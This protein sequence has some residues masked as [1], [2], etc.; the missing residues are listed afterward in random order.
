MGLPT[1]AAL[2]WS[3]RG[4]AVNGPDVE[5]VPLGAASETSSDGPFPKSLSMDAA[6][7]LDPLSDASVGVETVGL[8]SEES[9]GSA[10]GAAVD[11]VSIGAPQHG[12]ARP[13]IVNAC[14]G[15]DIESAT[16]PMESATALRG[17]AAG[18]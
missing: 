2:L 7:L 4:D 18:G 15:S 8:S 13:S 14:V 3:L 1:A 5:E 6:L 10:S 12:R 16:E 17:L 9:E 11:F